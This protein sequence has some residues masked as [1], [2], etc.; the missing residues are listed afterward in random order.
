MLR[1]F[2]HNADENVV[3]GR[4]L[5]VVGTGGLFYLAITCPCKPLYKC[6][7]LTAGALTFMGIMGVIISIF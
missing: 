1:I 4:A 7:A 2:G 6:H 3:I 5:L